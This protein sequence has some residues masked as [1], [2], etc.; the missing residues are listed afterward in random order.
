MPPPPGNFD[1]LRSTGAFSA[2]YLHFQPNISHPNYAQVSGNDGKIP[3]HQNPP[4]GMI[5]A[6]LSQKEYSI[7]LQPI[8]V[9][10]D[11]GRSFIVEGVSS[12]LSRMGGGGGGFAA[13][14]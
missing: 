8:R 5:F 12:A 7:Y 6:I 10:F 13:P 11:S 2:Q 1:S 3:L 9:H 4:I 14:S